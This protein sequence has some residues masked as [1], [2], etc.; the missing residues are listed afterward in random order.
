DIGKENSKYGSIV[1]SDLGADRMDYLKRDAI[2]TGVAYGVIDIDRIVHTLTIERGELCIEQGG[3]EA[4]E[5]MLFAR[6]IMFSTVYMH[7]TVRIATAMLYR[8]IEGAIED[9]T[10]EPQEFAEKG[11]DEIFMLLKKSKNGK[12][13]AEALE[14]RKLY[15]QVA[16]FSR[17]EWSE[18]SKKREKEYTN[19]RF[20]VDYPHQFFKPLSVKVKTADGK[21]KPIAELSQL[22]SGLKKSEEERMKV[23][24]LGAKSD[25]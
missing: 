23:L 15:K 2:N 11:D 10:V 8:A 7:H 14:S 6:F 12:R 16:S 13:Y 18:K 25:S 3:L 24:I 5:Y 22:L 21:L 4:A 19:D 9:K 1:T 20:I 17:E